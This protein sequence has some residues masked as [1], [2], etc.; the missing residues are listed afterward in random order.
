MPH[1]GYRLP[2]SNQIRINLARHQQVRNQEHHGLYLMNPQ[3][4]MRFLSTILIEPA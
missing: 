1:E 3:L 2:Y 4:A